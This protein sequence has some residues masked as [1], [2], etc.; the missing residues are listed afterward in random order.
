M[1]NALTEQNAAKMLLEAEDILIICHKNPDGDTLGSGFAMWSTLH[2]L[3][4]RA[5]IVCDSAFPGRYGYMLDKYNRDRCEDFEPRFIL[6]VDTAAKE[7]MGESLVSLASE[8]NLCIDHHM[9]NGGYAENLLLD[10][11]SASCCE[12]IA[13][14]IDEMGV[15]IDGYA[16]QC[17]YTGLATDTGCFRYSNTTSGTHLLAARLFD[18]GIDYEMLNRILFETKTRAR[19]ELERRALAG[20]EYACGGKLAFMT[21]TQE[22]LATAGADPSEVEGITAIPRT[23]EGVEAGVTLRELP[24]GTYKVSVRT[25]TVDASKIAAIFGGGGHVRAAGFECSGTPYDIKVAVVA[26]LEREL[27]I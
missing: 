4:K 1:S 18:I 5:R 22:M 15:T 24:T 11:K 9:L 23:I 16:A 12:I 6:A 2:R 21:I 26:A 19:V 10:A 14:V 20:M 25:F 7:L 8:T 27:S 17:L 3:K 13:R